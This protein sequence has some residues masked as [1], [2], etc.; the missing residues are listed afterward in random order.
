MSTITDID[1]FIAERNAALASLDEARIRAY[2]RRW[3]DGD[4]LSPDPEVFWGSVHKAITNLV[5]LPRELRLRSK[6]WLEARGLESRDP[7]DL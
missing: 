5:G 3:S 2:Y 1:D 6:E 7:G 4:E